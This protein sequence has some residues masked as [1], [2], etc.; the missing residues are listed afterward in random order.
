MGY[1]FQASGDSITYSN[2]GDPVGS[3][4]SWSIWADID[5][6][7]G[8]RGFLQHHKSGTGQGILL[9]SLSAGNVA[10]FVAGTSFMQRLS[11]GGVTVANTL[12]HL[13]YTWTGGDESST[14]NIYKNGTEV[15]Y[16]GPSDGSGLT[17]A[18]G[19]FTLGGSSA[20][21]SLVGTEYEVAY[22]PGIIL[23]AAE[24]TM[25]ANHISPRFIRPDV[26]AGGFHS[27]LIR[28]T[29]DIMGQGGAGTITGTPTVESHIRMIYPSPS[30]VV[31]VPAVVAAGRIMSSIVGGG[32]LAGSGGIAGQGGGLA[33]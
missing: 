12:I 24:I 4:G 19:K 21:N 20:G 5:N 2:V 22:W 18:T 3:G 31:G 15:G 1:N 7:G 26:L 29:Q 16:A 6:I 27:P 13:C 25:L 8:N 10:L 17:A 11:L 33:G 14:V 28:D 32:G 9:Y 23:S 30:I